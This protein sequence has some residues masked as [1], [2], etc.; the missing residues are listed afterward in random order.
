MAVGIAVKPGSSARQQ[1]RKRIQVMSKYR[2]KYSCA[3][4]DSSSTAE[5]PAVSS[6]QPEKAFPGRGEQRHLKHVPFRSQGTRGTNGAANGAAN[7][8]AS[9]TASLD[10]YRHHDACL[11][12]GKK[13]RHSKGKTLLI[14]IPLVIL[15]A[16]AVAGI[17]FAVT[18]L[19]AGEDIEPGVAVTVDIPEGSSTEEIAN[20]LRQAN[21]INDIPAFTKDVQYMNAE[22]SLK[23]GTYQLETLMDSTTL[24]NTLVVGPA[25]NGSSLTIPEGVTVEQV[26]TLVEETC[27]IPASNF[28]ERVYAASDYVSDYPFLKGVYNNSLEGFL[29]PKTYGVPTGSTADYVV[30]L[31]LDQFAKETSNL[32]LTYAQEHGMNL[33]DIVTM[34]SLIEKETAIPEERPMIASVIYNRLRDNMKLQIDATVV[35]A[36]GDDYSGG[37]VSYDD[38]EIDSP[39][40]TYL[41][42]EL[43][44][45]PICSPSIES[46][47]AAAHPDQT[48]YYY[49]VLK[50]KE[51]YHTFC[52]T[53]EEFEVAKDEYNKIFEIE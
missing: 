19:L 52:V 29:Y 18:G 17:V 39:Y 38:L 26:A 48:D 11:E 53:S 49:Y 30:R 13:P 40:N 45:G 6:L 12:N 46:I 27:D 44:V 36:L 42:D 8:T 43:P 28:L 34:G 14:V 20:I 37:D 22:Q 50:S 35:Y 2:G 1:H 33:F 10:A 9:Q 47:E 15:L 31:M 7:D 25:A 16:A 32:D 23:P 51:G 21:V 3:P 5:I 24:I 41:V 4:S